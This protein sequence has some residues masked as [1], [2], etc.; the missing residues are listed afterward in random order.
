MGRPRGWAAATTGRPAMRSPG[1]PPVG[2]REHRHRFWKAVADRLS[3]ED[4][5]G[6]GRRVAGG[7]N[8][9]GSVKVAGWR[10]SARSPCRAQVAINGASGDHAAARSK[11]WG[12][13]DHAADGPCAVDNFARVAPQRRDSQRVFGI[14]GHDRGAARRPAGPPPEDGYTVDRCCLRVDAR[15]CLSGRGSLGLRRLKILKPEGTP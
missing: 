15:K 1:R 4:A 3:S 10:R 12:A 14:S 2:R 9:G 6:G 7:G 11:S 13:R 5:G 8:G